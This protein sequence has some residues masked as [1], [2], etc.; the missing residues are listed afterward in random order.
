MTDVRVSPRAD[1]IAFMEHRNPRDDRGWVSVVDLQG[2]AHQLTE[3]FA[4][5]RGLAWS[6]DG[7]E[8]WFTA[9]RSGEAFELFSVSLG[10][11]VREQ[12]RVP[13]SLVIHDIAPDGTVL[14]SSAK[15][16]TPIFGLL[17]GEKV[18]RD[19][20]SLDQV[21]LID[22]SE[23]GRKFLFQYYGQS[24]GPTYASYLGSTDGSPPVRLGTGSALALS[25]DG[26]WVITFDDKSGG[27]FLQPVGAGDL[28]VMERSGF[29][30]NGDDS[31]CPDSTCI[32]FTGEETGKPPRA[33][34]QL[35]GGEKPV[36]LGPLG[37][38]SPLLSP[39]GKVV[40]ARKGA[41]PV[42]F[43]RSG[44]NLREV[45]GLDTDDRIIRWSPEHHDL[46]IY[47][48][49][50]GIQLFDLNPETGSRRLLRE[51]RTPEMG[52]DCRSTP[53]VR[54]RRW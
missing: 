48:V 14:L 40:L 31:W 49:Q 20:S 47:K 12:D 1:Q 13:T 18:E 37:V 21:R 22:L 9:T 16:S 43:D 52:G 50:H 30:D 8:I 24:S 28:R 34:I 33:Y 25:P 6:P 46:Y 23:D 10:G 53:Y 39:D 36:P 4:S 45:K 15:A 26:K 32:V 42:I 19:L 38:T 29:T 11:V 2:H 51:I 44:K 27:V 7:K 35:V 3:E 54:V 41:E 5:E 17:P